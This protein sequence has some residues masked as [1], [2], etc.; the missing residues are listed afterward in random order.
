[1]LDDG[2]ITSG[3]ME[4]LCRISCLKPPAWGFYCSLLVKNNIAR[5]LLVRWTLMR[6]WIVDWFDEGFVE[7]FKKNLEV[8]ISF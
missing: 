7:G 5:V 3:D 6:F 1:M 2:A 8:W 4:P